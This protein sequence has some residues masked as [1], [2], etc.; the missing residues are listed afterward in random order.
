[1]ATIPAKPTPVQF[2]GNGA[3]YRQASAEWKAIY[4]AATP[5]EVEAYL[6]NPGAAPSKPSSLEPQWAPDIAQQV[7]EQEAEIPDGF[8]TEPAE[9][10]R[11]V[12]EAAIE[13]SQLIG[14]E[15]LPSFAAG[16]GGGEV[17][18]EQPIVPVPEKQEPRK[19]RAKAAPKAAEP[20]GLEALLAS[21]IKPVETISQAEVTR[22]RLNGDIDTN[23][24]IL[25]GNL[26]PIQIL[27]AV[28]AFEPAVKALAA[29]VAK[30]HKAIDSIPDDL[31]E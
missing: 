31:L 19:P 5:E 23:L 10:L 26:P 20:E 11:E 22:R 17:N 1:M 30:L 21:L 29:A 2:K 8:Q 16:V 14:G 7:R 13:T 3:A 24:S 4:D 6:T 15:A 25:V 18:P 9:E 27:A 28:P 12:A